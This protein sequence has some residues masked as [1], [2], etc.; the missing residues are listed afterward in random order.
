[1][2]LVTLISDFGL[3]DHYCA[4]LKA[5]ILNLHQDIQFIDITH[6]VSTHDI[7]QAAYHLR[8]VSKKFPPCTVH[9]VSV[10]NYYSQDPEIICF[11]YNEQYY[12]GP[13]NGIFSLCFDSVDETQIYK[14]AY[15]EGADNIFSLVAHG[16]SLIAQKMSITEV[17]PPLQHYNKRIEVQPVTTENEIRATIIHVDKFENVILNVHREFFEYKCKGR[18][19]EIFFKYY[20]PVTQISQSYSDVAIGEVLCLFNAAHQMELSINMGKA[21]SQLDLLKDETIQIKFK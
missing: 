11:R 19:F 15:D 2:Q 13:N 6:Q 16:I 10:H 12:I 21:A 8:A 1:M 18:D 14:I 4:L 20:N 7:R 17:G 3:Q 5:R 9:V